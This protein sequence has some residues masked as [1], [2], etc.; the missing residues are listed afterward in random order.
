[1]D[2]SGA[3][4][5]AHAEEYADAII[6]I[7]PGF[8]GLSKEAQAAE[9]RNLIIEAEEAE[10]GCEVHFWRYADHVK[11]THSLVPPE[12][13]NT[14]EKSLRELL[15]PKTISERFDSVILALERRKIG[16]AGGSAVR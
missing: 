2:F 8:A 13:S 11:K 4:R 1:M 10:V 9:R 12:L 5:G 3:Q 7:T 15:S 16:L 14:F 6:S